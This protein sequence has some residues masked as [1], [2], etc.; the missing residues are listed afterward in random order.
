MLNLNKHLEFIE[1]A[2]YAKPIHIIGVGAVGSRIAEVLVRLGFDDLHIYDFDIVEDVNVT[3]QLYTFPD[4]GLAK[5]EAISR[6]L[7]EINPHVRLTLHERYEDQK[8]DGIVFLSVDSIATRRQIAT[9]HLRNLN[10]DLFIDVRMRLTDGQI[11]TARWG[12]GAEA[13]TFI[14]SMN[15]S[16]EEDL[17]PLSACGTSLSVAPTIL[18]LI[19]HAIMNMILF[20]KGME[21]KEVTFIDVMEFTNITIRHNQS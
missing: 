13:R 5:T 12:K 21:P 19:S 14:E 20:L 7:L 16:D 6:H 11:Y 10:I 2:S 17:T 18:T 4:I 3:N 9:R 15:F 8:L 1:P